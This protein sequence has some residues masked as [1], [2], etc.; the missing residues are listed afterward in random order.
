MT[1]FA[2]RIILSL[3]QNVI[4]IKTIV[5]QYVKLRQIDEEVKKM[6]AKKTGMDNVEV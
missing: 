6:M 1:N 5:Y 4:L 2:Y 3:K